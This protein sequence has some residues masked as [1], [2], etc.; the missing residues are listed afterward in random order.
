MAIVLVVGSLAAALRLL[1]WLAARVRRRG[2]GDNVMAPF[3]EIWHPAAHRIRAE[4]KVHEERMV[5]L[6]SAGDPERRGCWARRV[7]LE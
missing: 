3:E 2:I 4:I 6:P 5:P 7:S 1:V